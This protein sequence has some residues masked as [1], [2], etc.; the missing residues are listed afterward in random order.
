MKMT[1]SDSEALDEI[2]AIYARLM[3]G[4]VVD[5]GQESAVFDTIAA[6]VRETGRDVGGSPQR[7]CASHYPPGMQAESQRLH[8]EYNALVAAQ[9]AGAKNWV[10]VRRIVD[11]CNA[12]RIILVPGGENL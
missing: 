2:A 8:R 4:G 1:K 3:R 7:Q 10:E 6:I 9:R 5:Q 12:K 11:E